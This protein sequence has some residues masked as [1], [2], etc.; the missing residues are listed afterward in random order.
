[1]STP[2]KPGGEHHSKDTQNEYLERINSL[3]ALEKV[4]HFQV[5][6]NRMLRKGE[7]E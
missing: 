5:G 3:I 7:I 1:M 4:E 6:A 2:K